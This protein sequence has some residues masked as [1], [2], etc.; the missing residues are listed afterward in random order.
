MSFFYRLILYHHQFCLYL[1]PPRVWF[2]S[3]EWK[4]R[5][6]N[7]FDTIR[8]VTMVF[9]PITTRIC[10]SIINRFIHYIVFNFRCEKFIESNEK[11]FRSRSR[12]RSN[13]LRRVWQLFNIFSKNGR[14]TDRCRSMSQQFENVDEEKNSIEKF[15]FIGK[16]QLE[17]IWEIH[18]NEHLIGSTY[19][20]EWQTHRSNDSLN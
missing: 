12:Q 7:H 10:C 20:Q 13:A 15:I 14:I 9:S 2:I 16:I 18:S 11:F 17:R 1:L 6:W 4:K 8:S 19:P 5:T 3:N